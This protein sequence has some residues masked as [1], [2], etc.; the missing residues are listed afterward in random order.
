MQNDGVSPSLGAIVVDDFKSDVKQFKRSLNHLDS[1]KKMV[2]ETN[3]VIDKIEDDIPM[4]FD[5]WY[6]K[7]AAEQKEKAQ[8]PE[9]FFTG[10]VTPEANR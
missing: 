3:K 5:D 8:Y 7:E 2:V 1:V 10:L 6:D 9:R 4:G